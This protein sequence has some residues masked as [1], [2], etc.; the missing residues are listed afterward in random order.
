MN[1]YY[2]FQMVY[3]CNPCFFTPSIHQ[4]IQ[5]LTKGHA[6]EMLLVSFGASTNRC[7]SRTN[8]IHISLVSVD[9]ETARSS[10]V[11]TINKCLLGIYV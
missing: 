1:V 4:I 5:A 7:R 9:L 3:D 6:F 8:R 11:N 10:I 2:E